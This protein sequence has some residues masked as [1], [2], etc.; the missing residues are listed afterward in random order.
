M[1]G[2]QEKGEMRERERERSSAHPL[3]SLSLSTM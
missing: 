1:E 3:I 2:K